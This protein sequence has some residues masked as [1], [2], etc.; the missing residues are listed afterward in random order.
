M[1]VLIKYKYILA[2]IQLSNHYINWINNKG[3]NIKFKI[4]L[5]INIII[6]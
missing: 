2:V 1:T 4:L 3:L 6:D 5:T